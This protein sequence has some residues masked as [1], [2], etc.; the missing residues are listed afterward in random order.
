MTNGILAGLVSITAACDCVEPWAAFI[1]G[2]LGSLVY[3]LACKFMNWLQ[4]DDP[5]EATQVHGFCGIWGCV[6]LAFFKVTDGILYGGEESGKLLGIQL[7]GCLCIIAWVGVLSLIFFLIANAL[8]LLRLPAEKEILGGDLHYFGPINMA[9]E[10]AAV[11][12]DAHIELVTM[13]SVP[14]RKE[15]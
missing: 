13:A 5:L 8:G 3:C 12:L 10:L 15:S 4:V 2:I 11:D 14:K 9:R 1:I 7:L 6:A